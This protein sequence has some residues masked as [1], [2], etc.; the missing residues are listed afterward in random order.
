MPEFLV[1]PENPYLSAQVYEWMTTG[2]PASQ[3]RIESSQFRDSEPQSTYYK[4]YH[5]AELVDPLLDSVKP[6]EW[7]TVSS[8]DVL[9]RKILASYFLME[10][11]WFPAFQKDYFL[12]D[13]AAGRRS[14]CSSLLVNIVLA[15][16][17][18][19]P[20]RRWHPKSLFLF[21][22]TCRW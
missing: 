22:Y 21:A 16:G 3:R 9:M 8:D 20:R 10:Y 6:S 4:P 14:C 11:H 15:L 12:Q 19:S 18:V 17:S 13:M 1:S 7:T 5:A 2:M